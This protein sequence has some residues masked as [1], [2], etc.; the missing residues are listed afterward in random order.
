[1]RRLVLLAFLLPAPAGAQ[2]LSTIECAA[3]WPILSAAGETVKGVAKGARELDLASL[4][5]KV[6]EDTRR[7]IAR[8]EDAN[9]NLQPPLEEWSAAAS[10]LAQKVKAACGR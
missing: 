7:A 9:A 6:D 1:M 3:Y 5:G 2:T 8:L 10:D 4:R